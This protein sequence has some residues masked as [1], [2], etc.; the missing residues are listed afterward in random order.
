MTLNGERV[1]Q[2]ESPDRE[3]FL[4][5]RQLFLRERVVILG[6]KEVK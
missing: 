3:S 2:G 6:E 5:S 4:L 1:N